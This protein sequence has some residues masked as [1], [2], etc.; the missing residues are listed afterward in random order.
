MDVEQTSTI[1]RDKLSPDYIAIRNISNSRLSSK[2][3][4]AEQFYSAIAVSTKRLAM[5]TGK[6]K[7]LELRLRLAPRDHLKPFLYAISK[8]RH[9]AVRRRGTIGGRHQ[10]PET[11]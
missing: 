11:E 1:I 5:Q 2:A 6:P 3:V 7:T 4:T 8:L 10:P 9:R